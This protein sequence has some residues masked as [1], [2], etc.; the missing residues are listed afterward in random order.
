MANFPTKV[1]FGISLSCIWQTSSN[2]LSKV[3]W[4]HHIT[5][6]APPLSISLLE[7]HCL[8]HFLIHHFETV[9]NSKKLQ[10]TTEMWLLKNFSDMKTLWKMVKLLILSN[11]TFSHHVFQSFFLQCVK[12]SI[13]G[14]KG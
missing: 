6:Y 7:I 9:P 14:G 2:L 5:L 1:L 8:T 3:L 11:F 13:Y 12:L 10:T 4:L